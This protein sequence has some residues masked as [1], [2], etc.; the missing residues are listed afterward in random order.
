MDAK[1]VMTKASANHILA[2]CS[3]R[4]YSTFG[5]IPRFPSWRG[6]APAF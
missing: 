1:R 6:S 5:R 4:S 2:R 3:G